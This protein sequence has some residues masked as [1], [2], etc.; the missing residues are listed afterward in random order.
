MWFR[1]GI[2]MLGAFTTMLASTM[3]NAALPALSLDL[4]ASEAAS[5]WLVSGYLLA[6]ATGV[7]MSAWASRR[8]GPTRLWLIGLTLFAVSSAT[9]AVAP[10]MAALIGARMVQGLVGGLLV[11]VGQTIIGLVVNRQRLGRIISMIGIVIVV[12]PLLGTSLGALI[13][14]HGG[15]RAMFWAS[16]PLCVV[17]LGLGLRFLPKL[18]TGGSP[19][20]DWIGALLILAGLP[21]TLLGV[22]SG[23]L[24]GALSWR[25]G[26][27]VA[28]VLLIVG[29]SIRT[30]RADAPLLNLNLLADRSFAA[31]AAIMAIG[32][33]VSFGGQFLLPLYFMEVRGETLQATAVSLIPQILGSMVGFPFAGWLTDRY[34]ARL[35]LVSG[36]ILAALS[37]IPLAIIGAQAGNV[38]VELLIA[39]RG[40]GVALA[41]TPAMIAGLAIVERRHFSHAAPILN[42]FQR[43]GA[44]FGTALIA[45]VYGRGGSMS[46]LTRFHHS[47]LC[48]AAPAALIAVAAIV[49]TRSPAG[50][51]SARGAAALK[52]NA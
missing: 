35:V 1:A 15:W 4:H 6:L 7:P 22:T 36:G 18:E 27:L 26:T 25:V 47:S 37:T 5:A 30:L 21:L 39:V 51:S 11:P 9:C 32:G 28:G 50:H 43:L 12:A 41:T 49:I 33:A 17:A 31:C 42:I 38:S 10:N 3:T 20:L 34:D 40:F 24:P 48:L 14:D 52:R 8:V 45:S 29:F 19:S 46:A 23:A 44:A 16:V 13:V 2:A